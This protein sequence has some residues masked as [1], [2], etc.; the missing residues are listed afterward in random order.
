MAIGI[1]FNFSKLNKSPSN[2]L[3]QNKLGY[4]FKIVLAQTFLHC[5]LRQNTYLAGLLWHII[6]KKKTKL[7]NFND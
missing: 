3:I 2:K 6:Q 7:Y 1:T 5:N 4:L